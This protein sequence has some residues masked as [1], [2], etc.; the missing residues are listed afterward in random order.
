MTDEQVNAFMDATREI[1][2]TLGKV[3]VPPGV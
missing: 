2:P 3:E 1:S